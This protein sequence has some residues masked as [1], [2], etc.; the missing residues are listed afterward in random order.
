MRRP[1]MRVLLFCLPF[2]FTAGFAGGADPY[3][4]DPVHS[5]VGFSIKCLG[6]FRF[7][8]HFNE[9]T[10][11]ILFDEKAPQNSRVALVVNADSIDTASDT[12]DAHLKSKTYFNTKIYPNIVFIS[13]SVRQAG[14]DTYEVAGRLTLLSVTKPLTVSARFKGRGNDSEVGGL[15]GFTTS[16]IINRRDFGMT[17]GRLIVGDDV[18]MTISAVGGPASDA[19]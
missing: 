9:L 19:P 18:T 14:N 8:G 3:K 16:F 5:T 15:M 6:A 17:A 11:T 4:L 12:L 13:D 10:G 1:S 7:K 2:F